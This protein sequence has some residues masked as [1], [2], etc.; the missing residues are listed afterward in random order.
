MKVNDAVSG[1]FLCLFAAAVFW[2]TLGFPPMPGQRFGAELFPQ[3]IATLMG[4]SG[5][6]LIA[7]GLLAHNG[8]PW[9][10]MPDWARSPRHRMQAAVL[11][12]TLVFYIFASTPLG[13]IPTAIIVLTAVMTAL[14]GIGRIASTLLIAVVASVVMQQFFGGLLRVPLPYGIVPPTLF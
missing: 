13:F 7:K 5:L 1:A 2:R 11:L 14:R 3:V 8:G 12:A 6:A 9:A 10:T 4:L